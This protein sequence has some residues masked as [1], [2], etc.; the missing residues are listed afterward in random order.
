MNF[1]ITKVKSLISMIVSIL[2]GI[3]GGL[4]SLC[5]YEECG[6][7]RLKVGLIF[8]IVSLIVVYVI[9]SLIQKKK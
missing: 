2:I 5:F 6:L 3:I 9:W 4:F 8:F 1:K 7:F